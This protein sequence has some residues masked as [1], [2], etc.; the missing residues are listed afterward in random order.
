M[1]QVK[2][3]FNEQ[4]ERAEEEVNLAEMEVAK[5]KTDQGK[6]SLKLSE[7]RT[8]HKLSKYQVAAKEKEVTSMKKK[9]DLILQA[10][11]KEVASMKKRMTSQSRRQY[12]QWLI[13]ILL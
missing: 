3:V 8:V 9:T 5:V 4:I 2:A 7:M 1:I 12:S 13:E 6:T 10:K 11:E